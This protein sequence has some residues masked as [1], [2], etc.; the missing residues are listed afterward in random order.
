MIA[1]I[2]WLGAGVIFVVV[3]WLIL[4]MVLPFGARPPEQIEPGT[5][6]SAPAKPWLGLKFAVTTALAL[7]VTAGI[8]WLLQ[9]GLIELRPTS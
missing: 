3:W 2:D 7:V 6:A 1:D 9:S 8:L 4:F 5:S